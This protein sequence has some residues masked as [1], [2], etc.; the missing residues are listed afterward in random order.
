MSIILKYGPFEY[1]SPG[2]MTR[3]GPPSKFE[4]PA[5]S[6]NIWGGKTFTCLTIGRSIARLGRS[7]EDM[8]PVA[9]CAYCSIGTNLEINVLIPPK[10]HC[11]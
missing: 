2:E 7:S 11:Q 5:A 4:P 9:K 10:Y 8:P 1:K 6:K 3:P